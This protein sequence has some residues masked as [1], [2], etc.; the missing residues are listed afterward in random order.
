MTLL[1]LP[2]MS[3]GN[4]LLGFNPVSRGLFLIFGESGNVLEKNFDLLDKLEKLLQ[5]RLPEVYIELNNLLER[6]HVEPARA[7]LTWRAGSERKTIRP[8]AL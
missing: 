3:A 1:N 6:H 5:T 2:N 4:N 7:Q 8:S